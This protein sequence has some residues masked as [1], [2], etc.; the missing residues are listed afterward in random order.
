[1]EGKIER[2]GGAR[3]GAGRPF[4]NGRSR[5]EYKSILITKEAY[6]LLQ[7]VRNKCVYVSDLITQNLTKEGA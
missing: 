4:K 7:G 2:R 5:A 3:P 6:A 1:M